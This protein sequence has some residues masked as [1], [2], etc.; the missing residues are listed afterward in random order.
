MSFEED[1][2]DAEEV[3][4]WIVKVNPKGKKGLQHLMNVNSFLIKNRIVE[5]RG[6]YIARLYR[7]QKNTLTLKDQLMRYATIL[8]Q[9]I[10]FGNTSVGEVKDLLEDF[11][12]K[13]IAPE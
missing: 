7:V 11:K 5:S 12:K 2:P 8:K 13:V 1:F 4:Y 3:A 10:D 9:S 6:E